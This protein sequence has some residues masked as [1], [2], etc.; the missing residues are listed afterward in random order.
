MLSGEQVPVESPRG[1]EDALK[2]ARF[3]G[4]RTSGLFVR[5]LRHAIVVRSAR[6][7][8]NEEVEMIGHPAMAKHLHESPSFRKS[9]IGYRR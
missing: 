3:H 5:K 7:G 9:R 8:L 6:R 1:A 4:S 2:Q